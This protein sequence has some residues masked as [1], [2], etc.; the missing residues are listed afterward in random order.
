MTA[1]HVAQ[2]Q[3]TGDSLWDPALIARYNLA[4][5]RYTSYPTAA[6][7]QED[8][9]DS[10]WREAVKASNVSSAPL[11]LYFHIPFC[12]TVCY[13]CACNKIITANRQRAT[14]YL[15]VLY[16]EIALQRSM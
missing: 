4:G 16:R 5:P 13:Y 2:P 15:Q 6:Q 12:N 14:D 7:F 11:S 8:V 9:S 10:L 1:L 3:L